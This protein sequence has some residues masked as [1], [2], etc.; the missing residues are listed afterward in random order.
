[1]IIHHHSLGELNVLGHLSNQ[2]YVIPSFHVRYMVAGE[3]GWSGRNARENA[4][5]ECQQE[6]GIVTRLNH[7]L[8]GVTVRE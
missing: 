1:M 8:V 6:F 4:V 7:S 3:V 2:D 5:L